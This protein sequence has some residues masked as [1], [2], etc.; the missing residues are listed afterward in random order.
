MVHSD[1]KHLQ[2]TSYHII[3]ATKEFIM[4]D[5]HKDQSRIYSAR[6]FSC[7]EPVHCALII[8]DS[9]CVFFRFFLLLIL[10]FVYLLFCLFVC[11]VMYL[12]APTSDIISGF[13]N[14]FVNKRKINQMFS[15]FRPILLSIYLYTAAYFVCVNIC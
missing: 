15:Y 7:L 13:A 14:L 10:L 6:L 8:C 11:L 3:R 12:V 9:E 5:K 1:G 2:M 4:R